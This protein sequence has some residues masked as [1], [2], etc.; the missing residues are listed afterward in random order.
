MGS[1]SSF[2]VGLINALY[3]LKNKKMLKIDLAKKTIH[4]EQK[5]MNE[6]V[7]S[8]DQIASSFGGFNKII[9][10]KNKK[11]KIQKIVRNK[12]V[13]LLEN[14]LILIYTKINRTA[15]K[16]ASKY[17]NQLTSTKKDYIKKILEHVNEGENILNN[18]KIDDF[19]KLLDSS[20]YLKK[21]LSKS[22]SNN[23]IDDLYDNAMKCGATGGKLLGAGGGGFLLIYMKNK[24]RNNFFK[25]NPKI[26]NV[27]F[28]FSDNGSQVIFKH[29]KR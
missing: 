18:G 7:G 3:A 11:I 1:S 22:I 12:N 28:R 14:N 23:K 13:R 21:K 15:H 20:W 19:G 17:V 10:N 24:Y 8:Q 5:V 6:T 29:L 9:F 27:P 2:S 26:I 4:F 16:I 25:K